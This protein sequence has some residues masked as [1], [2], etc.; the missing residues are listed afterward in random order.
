[1]N[2]PTAPILSRDNLVE[3]TALNRRDAKNAEKTSP[4]PAPY[5]SLNG[6]W[7]ES[8]STGVFLCVLRVSAVCRNV[9]IEWIRLSSIPNFLKRCALFF[10]LFGTNI[11]ARPPSLERLHHRVGVSLLMLPILG[12]VWMAAR[13]P[14]ISVFNGGVPRFVLSGKLISEPFNIVHAG[15]ALDQP[16]IGKWLFWFSVMAVS[17]LPYAA[18]VGWLADRGTPS[19]RLTF[20]IAAGVL[21]VF[22]LCMLSWPLSWLIQYVYSMGFTPRRTYGLVY[23]IA[24][25]LLVIG[26]VA[27]AFRNPKRKDAE[28]AYA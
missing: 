22:L 12:W 1:M 13:E 11:T 4:R 24:G 21:G 27:W 5:G 25:G 6:G 17:S 3:T 26:F 10:K 18:V 15:F 9:P 2:T 28:P 7:L 19:G 20:G 23:A 16:T 14:V 8:S